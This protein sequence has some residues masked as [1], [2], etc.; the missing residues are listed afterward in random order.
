MRAIKRL[1]KKLFLAFG[2]DIIPK[3]EERVSAGNFLSLVSAYEYQLNKLEATNIQTGNDL[4]HSLLGRL[5]GTPPSQA[6]EIISMLSNTAHIAGDICEFG[7]AQGETSALIANEICKGEKFLHLFDSFEGLPSPTEKDQLKDDIFSLGSMNAY[8]GKMSCPVDMVKKRLTSI[9]FPESRYLIHQG[10]IEDL[11]NE[12][13]DFPASVSFAYVDF[14]FYEP[15]KIALAFLD[16]TL[17]KGGVI[18]VDDYDYFS[19]GAKS[20]T[21]E[22]ITRM[23]RSRQTYKLEVAD[24]QLGH[25]ACITKL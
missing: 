7:V 25:F 24:S 22:F 23:N 16:K 19:T 20:A 9:G 17:T 13:R 18:M 5:L 6:F 8:Q 3:S 15:I 10:F 2:F 4:R 21:D 1:V 12:K 11:V 14:D